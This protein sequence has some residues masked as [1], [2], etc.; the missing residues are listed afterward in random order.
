MAENQRSIENQIT[1]LG[2]IERAE[3]RIARQ[4]QIVE[5]LKTF[6]CAE[7]AQRLLEMMEQTLE[8]LRE[9]ERELSTPPSTEPAA[10]PEQTPAP[11]Q[12]SGPSS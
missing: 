3:Q 12:E 4:R 8:S 6:N 1:V 7:P 11:E 9:Q 10:A 2:R 5:E